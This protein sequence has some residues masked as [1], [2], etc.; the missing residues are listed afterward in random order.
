M[1]RAQTERAHTC[2][3]LASAGPDAPTLCEGWTAHDLAAHLWL[4][5]NEFINALGFNVSALADRTNRRVEQLK[6][7]LQFTELVDL[8]RA[9]PPRFSLFGIPALDETGNGVEYLIHGMDVRRPNGQP[10]PE[11]DE[12]FQ[13]WCWSALE[14][15]AKFMLGKSDAGIILEWEGRP[16]RSLRAAK[17][18]RIVTVLGEPSELLLYAFGRRS[19]ADVRL[20]GLDSALAALER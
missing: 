11:R 18:D 12:E 19:S 9:G 3:A 2:D 16:D 13:Q 5:E 8:V 10:E 15:A 6:Q 14:R 4:R 1:R 20:V 17:G 7:Q